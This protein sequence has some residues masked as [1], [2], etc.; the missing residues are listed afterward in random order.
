MG[1]G[2][3]TAAVML[4]AI[5][6]V[7]SKHLTMLYA[8]PL[9]MAL[10]YGINLGL[11]V[12]FFGPRHGRAILRVNRP[13]LVGLRAASLTLGSLMMGLA[14]RHM[15]VAETVAI[16]YLSP[17]LV[18]IAAVW[19]MGEAASP[20]AWIGA[21]IG[22][23]GVLLIARPGSGLDFW[24]VIFSLI[25]AVCAAT[26]NLLSRE[27]AKTETTP[28]LMFHT[29]WVGLAAFCV[30]LAATGAG[31]LP[32]GFDWAYI[33]LLGII[34]LAVAMAVLHGTGS[35]AHAI[36]WATLSGLAEPLGAALAYAFVNPSSSASSFG[37]MFA[38]SAG[39][40][41]Y[42]C[43]TELLPA[44]YREHPSARLVAHAFLAGCAVMASSLV[45]EKFNNESADGPP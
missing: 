6:D 20:A 41:V 12:A 15:P 25:N 21:A 29:A 9:V 43:L 44:A 35:R 23:A 14:L 8:V 39:M 16:I 1:I 17:F 5:G 28:A 2:L 22:F 38:V 40:M 30:M 24:G 27:L 32:Q 33:A 18:M 7:A 36:G 11:I 13:W 3:I 19:L 45:L 10:R 4:F 42:V 34:G 37:G 26:Y 31:A